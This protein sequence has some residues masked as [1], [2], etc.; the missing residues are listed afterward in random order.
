MSL[1]CLGPCT[2]STGNASRLLMPTE[3]VRSQVGQL[4]VYNIQKLV[5]NIQKLVYNIQKLYTVG[6][7]EITEITLLWQTSF[8]IPYSTVYICTHLQ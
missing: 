1:F 6:Q 7:F 5:Y 2:F 8:S 4:R 3:T